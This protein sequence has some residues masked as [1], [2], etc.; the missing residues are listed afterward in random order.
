MPAV[1]A[2]VVLKTA[3]AV[4]ENYITNSFCFDGTDPIADSTALTTA[5]S[6]FYVSIKALLS[7]L[8]AIAGHEVKYYDLPGTPPNYPIDTDTFTFGSGFAGSTLPSE[9]AMC[10]SF[11]GVKLAGSPQARRR[12]RVYIGPLAVGTLDTNG[13][14]TSTSRT[15]LA[16]AGGT[17]KGAV[18]AIASDVAWA[19]WSPSNQAAVPVADGWV[20]DAFDTQRRRGV[21]R[22][23]RNTFT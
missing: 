4:P 5:I 16:N 13:R 2:Q 12:G 9:V 14:P 15:T 22:T 21:V 3:D 8:L 17:F 11:Q 19:V 23:T 7:P 18:T 20:D 6:A 1:R 10:L